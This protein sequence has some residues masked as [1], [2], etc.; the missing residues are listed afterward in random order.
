[1][2]REYFRN[3]SALKREYSFKTEIMLIYSRECR[4]FFGNTSVFKKK[5]RGNIWGIFRES[6]R[7]A[8]KF[9]IYSCKKYSYCGICVGISWYSCGIPV[10]FPLY[11]HKK[12][13]N[14]G[15]ISGILWYSWNIP[16]IRN[17]ISVFL[18]YSC[19]NTSGIYQE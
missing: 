8:V 11:S 15:N 10:K 7:N 19:G 16:E 12:A 9:L 2:L 3:T 14:A 5:C 6:F 13:G 4:N 17:I 1:M 18:W